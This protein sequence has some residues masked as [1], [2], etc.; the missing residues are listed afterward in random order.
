MSGDGVVSRFTTD[1]NLPSL[2]LPMPGR[3]RDLDLSADGQT[4]VATSTESGV[5]AW[6]PESGAVRSRMQPLPPI[7]GHVALSPDGKRYAAS[8]A[9]RDVVLV[10]QVDTGLLAMPPLTNETSVVAAHFSP[11]N[12][13]LAVVTTSGLVALWELPVDSM[14][15]TST[16][17][18]PPRAVRCDVADRH[19]GVVWTAHFSEDG[20]L[21]VTASSDRTARLREVETGRLIA[22]LRHSKPVYQARFGPGA[23]QVI[24]GSGDHT[25]RIWDVATRQPLGEP[26][27]HP[28]GVWYGE[29]S[30]D[31]EQVLTGDDTG[32]ARFWN[33]RSG[34][35]LNGWIR[36][37]SSLRRA[38]LTPDARPAPVASVDDGVRLS[39]PLLAPGPAPSWLPELA[40]AIARVR[41]SGPRTFDPVPTRQ[42]AE[43]RARLID[44]SGAG[45]AARAGAGE[46]FYS[47]WAYWFLV[48]R[49]RPDPSAFP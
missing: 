26:M 12:R 45:A 31:G 42:L 35:P 29:F 48:E 36:H 25:A 10:H 24:T 18:T 8:V 19:E 38:R 34:L 39:R 11:D 3:V 13:R 14:T 30:A 49:M 47:R 43:L 4:L 22:E 20:R 46:D 21:L 16:L 2:A 40:E 17:R 37:G 41:Q 28:G 6:D 5:V 7:L 23:R 44:G 1:S 9:E 15:S 27:E 32:H 33:A